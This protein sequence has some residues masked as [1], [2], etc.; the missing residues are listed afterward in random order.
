MNLLRDGL[1]MLEKTSRTFFIPISR[2]PNGLKEAVTS[3][4][5]CMRAIDEIEDHP[6]LEGTIKAKL[7]QII[8]ISLQ[9]GVT[10]STIDTIS[11]RLQSHSHLSLPDVSLRVGEW[12]I[13]APPD[14][15]PGSGMQLLLWQTVWLTGRQLTGRYIQG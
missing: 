4:Y 6:H 13:M 8:S 14:I 11:Q 3:A 15:A 2:L 12:A 9:E 5:L 7:L 10:N 1:A